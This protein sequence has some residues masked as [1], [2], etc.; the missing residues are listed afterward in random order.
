[1]A[2]L[3]TDPDRGAEVMHWF[4][5]WA[6]QLALPQ[7]TVRALEAVVR[8]D[9]LAAVLEGGLQRLAHPNPEENAEDWVRT[10]LAQ[11]GTGT[12]STQGVTADAAALEHLNA[13]FREEGGKGIP[14]LRWGFADLDVITGGLEPGTLVIVA[15][16]PSVGKSTFALNTLRHISGEQ[17]H[18]AVLI[19]LEMS[20]RQVVSQWVAQISG[21]DTALVHRDWRQ[22]HQ[23]AYNGAIEAIRQ[24][25]VTIHDHPCTVEDVEEIA[26]VAHAEGRCAVCVVDYVDLIQRET[27]GVTLPEQLGR[28][29]RRLKA[30]AQRLQIPLI[31]LA[32]VN[33]NVETRNE[34]RPTLA[35]LR[36]SGD[37]EASAD[38][39]IFL[40]RTAPDAQRTEVTIAKNRMGPL[41]EFGLYWDPRHTRFGN[42]AKS[43]VAQG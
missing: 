21:I 9:Q 42:L 3:A 15:A 12:L 26:T 20:A 16:R 41:A 38:Q 34:A 5:Q 37:L 14:R 36:N 23:P 27:K 2:F 1:M 31:L 10:Q 19:T 32:Q 4:E 11:L 30:L 43:E 40:W 33:R 17:G 39:V 8:R 13:K 22:A 6:D 18:P 35:D 28:I 25:P 7:V 24:W 29:A